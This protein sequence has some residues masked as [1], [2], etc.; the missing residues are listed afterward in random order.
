MICAWSK[1][2]GGSSAVR[3]D[4]RLGR[5]VAAAR[6]AVGLREKDRADRVLPRVARR[7]RVGVKLPPETHDE[8]RLLERLARRRGLKR[9]ARVDEAAGQRPAERRVLPP[10][11]HDPAAG[12]DDH[13]DRRHRVHKLRIMSWKFFHQ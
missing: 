13:I 7:V 3:E 8:P 10:H 12:A 4:A 5:V 2:S 11:E 1:T 6:D 9:L